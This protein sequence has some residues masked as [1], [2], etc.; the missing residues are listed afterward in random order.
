MLGSHEGK[1]VAAIELNASQGESYS[2]DGQII[3]GNSQDAL[4]MGRLGK[5]QEFRRNFRI[6]ST[7]AFTSCV[8]GTWEILLTANTQGLTAG[9][10]AGIFW[11]LVWCYAGQLFVILSLAEMSAMAPVR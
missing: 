1:D 9:G 3:T 6:V 8:M 7:V 11:S 4:D 5:K 2:Y 10:L